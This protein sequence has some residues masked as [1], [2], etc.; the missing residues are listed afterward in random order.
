MNSLIDSFHNLKINNGNTI[1]VGLDIGG[2]LTIFAISIKKD[3]LCQEL[4][5]KLKEEIE[6]SDQI[7]LKENIIF[8]I[9][10]QTHNFRTEGKDLLKSKK[11]Q[12]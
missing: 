3:D 8:M 12:T 9:L 7:E 11:L 2:S 6:F 5:S 10:M 4:I 1:E